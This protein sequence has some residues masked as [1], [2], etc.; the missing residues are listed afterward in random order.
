M[1]MN[2]L[3]TTGNKNTTLTISAEQLAEITERFEQ[4]LQEAEQPF[5]GWDFGYITGSERLQSGVLPWSYGTLA[6]RCM[7]DTKR[8]LDMGTGGGELLSSLI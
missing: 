5:H 1:N 8:M 4:G 3:N 7:K 2:T 6:R